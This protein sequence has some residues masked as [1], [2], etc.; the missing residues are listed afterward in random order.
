MVEIAT[1]YHKKLQEADSTSWGTPQDD[2]HMSETLEVL[3]SRLDDAER[4]MT[5]VPIQYVE[6]I[7][8]LTEVPND[9]ATGLDRIPVELWKKLHRTY[10]DLTAEGDNKPFN[11][12]GAMQRVFNDIQQRGVS[13]GTLFTD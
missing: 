7:T 12:I 5:G 10:K 3:S 8:S 4:D 2:R 1:E 6:V 9:K 11:V 13:K